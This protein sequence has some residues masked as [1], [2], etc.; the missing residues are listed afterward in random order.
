[1]NHLPLSSAK[2]LDKKESSSE[3]K[4][5]VHSVKLP[6]VTARQ[7][8]THFNKSSEAVK[9]LE[10]PETARVKGNSRS[11]K[12]VNEEV[13]KTPV[14]SEDTESVAK[15]KNPS[16]NTKPSIPQAYEDPLPSMPGP[17]SLQLLQEI[18]VNANKA[19]TIRNSKKFPALSED[20]LV[21]IV[22]VHKREGYLKQLLESL[23]VARGIEKVLLVISHDYYYDDMN[24]L[25]ESVDF[26]PVGMRRC[27]F[28]G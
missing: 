16:N 20:S 8:Q 4:A 14:L 1:M 19:Q 24:K 11:P 10:K 13:L 12:Q 2:L 7:V 26:C 3:K 22:Q 17:N 9:Q 15:Y 23:K 5:S 28:S 18:L 6:V 27:S 21:L 25:I